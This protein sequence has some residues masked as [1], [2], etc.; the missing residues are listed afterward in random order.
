MSLKFYA[1]PA[2]S[3]K[4]TALLKEMIDRSL[5]EPE[6]KFFVI[7]PEQFTNDTQRLCLRLHP[8]RGL[9]NIDVLSVS[10]LAY[11]VQSELGGTG[12]EMLEEIGKSFIVEKIALDLGK[13]LP[14]FGEGLARPG[15]A[16][17]MKSLISECMLYD[18]KPVKPSRMTVASRRS[19]ERGS[20][21]A[22]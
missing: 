5:K 22:R 9:M 17:E 21:R 19:S 6:R 3:G 15:N 12:E 10:R 7:V 8:R 13:K 16:A 11:R 4:T 2:G 20:N 18:V 14:F 1:G